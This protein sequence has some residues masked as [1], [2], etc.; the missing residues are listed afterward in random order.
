MAHCSNS[1]IVLKSIEELRVKKKRRDHETVVLHA[2]KNHG[3]KV[4]DGRD[5]LCY[6]MNKGSVIN[7]PTQ[8]GHISFFLN[9]NETDGSKTT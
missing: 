2:E 3:L 9:Q 8:A 7:K 5:S 6:L 1:L 4:E